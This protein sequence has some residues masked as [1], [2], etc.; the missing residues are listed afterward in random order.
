MRTPILISLLAA[1]ICA[2]GNDEDPTPDPPDGNRPPPRIIEGG[3]IDDGPID[4]VV[5]LYVI[6]DV[7][8][9]P[10]AGAS[11]RIGELD[12]TTD[13]SGLFIAEEVFGPQ[14]VSVKSGA[15]RPEVWIG[16]NGANMTV[17]LVKADR[18]SPAS[19][20][21]AGQIAGFAGLTVAAGHAKD[22]VVVYSQ[23]TDLGDPANEISNTMNACFVRLAGQDC[24]FTL[25]ARTGKVALI[26]AIYD[27]NLNG[28]P[29]MFDDDTLTLMGW[30]VRRDVSVSAGTTPVTGMDLTLLSPGELQTVTIDFG[31]A[32]LASAAALV[33]LDLG[34]EG[35]FQLPAF[36][37]RPTGSGPPATLL[38]P[39]PEAVSATGYRLTAISADAQPATQQSVV[40]RK[41]LAGPTLSAGEWLA[42]PTG[43][44]V[45]RTGASW[46]A[47]A[48][49]TVH[50]IELRSGTTEVLNV[51]VLDGSTRFT[52]PDLIALPTGSLTATVNAIGAPGLDVTSFSLDADEDKLV[53]VAGQIVELN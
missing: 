35:V 34:D 23:T 4:G 30:A 13:A 6:D 47:A 51:T 5:N 29:T 41:G 52:V 49:A 19:G 53:Q 14:T 26:A 32:P 37:V 10:V 18:S 21:L 15:Y 44:S 25:E 27:R 36:A 11:V 7:T 50:G 28:T 8:R 33:G 16:A 17:N 46:T 45:T 39:R 38:V 40:L 42:A 31:A 12:G 43:V 2:C 3:G 24:T 9:D 48:G 20:V 1:S 22:A